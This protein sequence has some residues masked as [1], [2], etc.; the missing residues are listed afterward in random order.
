MR[1]RNHAGPALCVCAWLLASSSAVIA[2]AINTFDP[3]GSI[4]TYAYA[5]NSY[6]VI[7][8]SNSDSKHVFHAFHRKSHGRTHGNWYDSNHPEPR[9]RAD[10]MRAPVK[11]FR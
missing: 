5:I 1:L 7:T 2:Q 6:G 10:S 4:G 9:L 8:G 11:P 3:A